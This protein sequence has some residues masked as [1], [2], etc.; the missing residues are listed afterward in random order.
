VFAGGRH[1]PE[2]EV[3][4]GR[5]RIEPLDVECVD[6]A[7]RLDTRLRLLLETRHPLRA[8]HPKC[9]ARR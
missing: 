6:R 5:P 1:G 4:L 9:R 3:P 2:R 7:G 8:G